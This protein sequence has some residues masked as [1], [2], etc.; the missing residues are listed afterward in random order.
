MVILQSSLKAQCTAPPETILGGF[1][2]RGMYVSDGE[3]LIKEIEMTRVTATSTLPY[4]DLT[5]GSSCLTPK[6]RDLFIYASANNFNYL[7]VYGLGKKLTDSFG[8]NYTIVG[9]T[10]FNDAL[11]AF[12]EYAHLHFIKI[13]AVVT[14]ENF[15][16]NL[17]L[18]GS[19]INSNGN[20]YFSSSPFY[21]NFAGDFA[22]ASRTTH[23]SSTNI[24]A[25]RDTIEDEIP[26]EDDPIDTLEIEEAFYD[27]I[28][29]NPSD[30]SFRAIQLSEMLKQLYRIAKFSYEMRDRY[31]TIDHTS[32]TPPLSANLF[33]YIS[34]EFEYWDWN[35]GTYGKY[36]SDAFTDPDLAKRLY[37]ND[38]AQI[39][40]ATSGICRHLCWNTRSET[41]LKL[42]QPQNLVQYDLNFPLSIAEQASFISSYLNRALLTSYTQYYQYIDGSSNATSP[43]VL[44]KTAA[45][46]GTFADVYPPQF[47]FSGYYPA[48]STTLSNFFE[49]WPIFSAQTSGEEKHDFG[50]P[51]ATYWPNSN[52][53]GPALAGGTKMCEIEEN[54]QNAFYGYDGVGLTTGTYNFPAIPNYTVVPG[55][56]YKHTNSNNTDSYAL[57]GGFMWYNY[58]QLSNPN[59]TPINYNRLKEKNNK[60]ENQA[61]CKMIFV[62]SEKLLKIEQSGT[63]YTALEIYDSHGKILLNASVIGYNSIYLE[64]LKSGFYISKLISVSEKPIVRKI[65]IVN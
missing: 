28:L 64:T 12:L 23:S 32:T 37:W 51:N 26:G 30:T 1:Q 48:Y 25:Q 55:Y 27:S 6:T 38:Y 58:M 63:D 57:V 45:A 61:Y 41:E 29:V 11:R 34:I 4:I 59:R 31:N 22:C 15:L 42:I 35:G 20:Y 62:E 53:Y 19:P 8:A 9:N 18:Y 47:M 3:V 54:Y 65:L 36:L 17:D 52:Y 5:S 56:H 39:V 2:N 7:A 46:I 16:T 49:V 60:F 50:I 43:S 14:N 40:Y 13:G 10:L 33:D 24:Y 44:D 21:Y